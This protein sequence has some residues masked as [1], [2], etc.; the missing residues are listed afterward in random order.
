M[1]RI[2]RNTSLVVGLAVALMACGEGAAGE[3][4]QTAVATGGKPP[5]PTTAEI[6]A[7]VGYPVQSRPVPVDGCLYELTGEYAGVMVSLMYQPAARAEDIYADIRRGV[8]GAKGM[9]ATPDELTVGEGG[10]GY[11]SRGQKHAAAVSKGRVYHVEIDHNLFESIAFPDDVAV[12]VIELGM[13]VAPG[14]GASAGAATA[15]AGGS[16][17]AP[18]DACT[19]ATNA[20]VAQASE[21][22]P[23]IAQYWSAPVASLGNSH[24]DYDGGSIRVYRGKAAAASFESTLKAF[25]AEKA[26]RTPVSGIGDRAYFLI[27]YPD[28]PYKRLGLLAVHAGPDV[29]QFTFDAHGDEPIEATRPRL[30]K[31]ARLVLPRLP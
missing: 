28:D 29:L 5:C 26:P 13:R 22:R 18:I 23:E 20:E 30:E 3:P 17:S 1:Q 10:W 21:E 16:G 24:C 4:Q 12:K 8:Q 6:Q 15:S 25:G 9:S 2:A 14:P 19:L 27:P 11:T 31:L 7:A